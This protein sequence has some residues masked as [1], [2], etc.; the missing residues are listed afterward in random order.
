MPYS[1]P[2]SGSLDGF[3]VMM[4]SNIADSLYQF[5]RELVVELLNMGAQ[6]HLVSPEGQYIEYF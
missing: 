6:V 2:A 5:R 3:K 1:S 4:I